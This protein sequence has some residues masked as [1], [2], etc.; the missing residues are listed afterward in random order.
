MCLEWI[1]TQAPTAH[2]G[3]TSQVHNL[4]ALRIPDFQ[5]CMQMKKEPHAI[6]HICVLRKKGA[7]RNGDKIRN[8]KPNYGEHT[9]P[10]K[11]T[12]AHST[13]ARKKSSPRMPST[14]TCE[15]LC[16]DD[17][18]SFMSTWSCTTS[19]QTDI[20]PIRRPCDKRNFATIT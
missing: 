12:V 20:A 2:V 17:A 19:K 7:M 10:G 4:K 13:A 9:S 8:K 1:A 11:F 14:T 3:F 16:E 15:G 5:K 18:S 6:A